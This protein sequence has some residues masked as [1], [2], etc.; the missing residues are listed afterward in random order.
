MGLNN[1]IN[2]YFIC[3]T[4]SGNLGDLMINKMLIDELCKYGHVYLDAFGLPD[5]FKYPIL[6]N[7][8]VI[9]VSSYNLTVKRFSIKNFLKYISLLVKA[10]IKHITRSPGPL[11]EPSIKVRL[12]FII[13]NKLAQMCG[14]KVIYWGSCCSES[15]AH[16]HRLKS[17]HMDEVYIRSAEMLEYA[18]KSLKCPIFFIPDMAFLMYS[19]KLNKKNRIA[20]VDYRAMLDCNDVSVSDLKAIVHEFRLLG[21]AVELYYQV[22]SDKVNMLS[23]YDALREEGVTM[24]SEILAYKDIEKYYS[25]KSFVISNR[26][27]SLLFGAV[28][29]VIPIARITDD[30]RVIKIK[31]VFNSSLPET[32]CK[33]INININEP[34]NVKHIVNNIIQYQKELKL[35]MTDNKM[36]ISST[37]NA[38]LANL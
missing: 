34:L 36:K 18:R 26:L 17:T 35:V 14:A 20:I 10:N 23:L 29:G 38:V 21:Y 8:H 27:H 30:P 4:Q 12:G 2:T 28:H 31:H 3:A 7:E 13:I 37:I 33:N 22:K 32:F 9:D 25:D 24:R 11:E 5:E 6:E 16:G 1:K 19:S 15:F